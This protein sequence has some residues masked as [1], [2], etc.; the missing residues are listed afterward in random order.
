MT[1]SGEAQVLP[2]LCLSDNR[3]QRVRAGVLPRQDVPEQARAGDRPH[4]EGVAG[5]LLCSGL[6]RHRNSQVGGGGGGGL[7][8]TPENIAET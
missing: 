5:R 2:G 4:A 7:P 6:R 8:Q 3:F 1:V